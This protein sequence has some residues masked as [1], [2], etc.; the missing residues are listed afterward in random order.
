MMV[1]GVLRMTGEQR[2]GAGLQ[3]GQLVVLLVRHDAAVH[4]GHR[5]HAPA[6]LGQLREGQ[7]WLGLGL[8]SPG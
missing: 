1:R 3:L 8:G 2:V 5:L 4:D 7:P 6:A